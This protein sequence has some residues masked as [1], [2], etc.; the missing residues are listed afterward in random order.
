MDEREVG[1]VL[2]SQIEASEVG[3]IG[4]IAFDDGGKRE[5]FQNR[6]WTTVGRFLRNHPPEICDTNAAMV[7]YAI[8]LAAQEHYGDVESETGS[9]IWPVIERNVSER[10]PEVGQLDGSLQQK[11]GDVY[12][13]ALRHF[14][15]K[16]PED[17]SLSTGAYP[18]IGP[19]LFHAGFAG[20]TVKPVVSLV[21]RAQQSI[22]SFES[23][24]DADMRREWF[25]T[26]QSGT[27]ATLHVWPRR[28]L[29]N[30][31][32]VAEPLWQT[33]VT[34]V[35]MHD[36]DEARADWDE[37]FIRSF[38]LPGFNSRLV[39]DALQAET[40]TDVHKT[41]RGVK[42]KL[43]FGAPGDPP[44]PRLFIGSDVEA[45]L[46]MS[47]QI[48]G[49]NE[50]VEAKI[51]TNRRGTFVELDRPVE[52]VELQLFDQSAADISSP[53]RT[54]RL[55]SK[56]DPFVVFSGYGGSILDAKVVRTQGVYSGTRI[57]LCRGAAEFDG[58]N[59]KPVESFLWYFEKED[60]R[61]TAWE[62]EIPDEVHELRFSI[63]DREYDLPVSR[64]RR[65]PIRLDPASDQYRLTG[66][67]AISQDDAV[68]DV[69]S[70]HP[71]IRQD[72]G[73]P[74]MVT[75]DHEGHRFSLRRINHRCRLKPD[76]GQQLTKGSGIF[77]I[78]RW[79]FPQKE[80]ARYAVVPGLKFRCNHDPLSRKATFEITA[81]SDLGAFR[82]ADADIGL[83]Q[84]G[85]TWQFTVPCDQPTRCIEWIDFD[86]EDNHRQ[87]VLIEFAVPGVR[88]RTVHLGADTDE[89]WTDQR[90]CLE[91]HA[92]STDGT[93]L[94]IE[95]PFDWKLSLPGGQLESPGRRTFSGI[96]HRLRLTGK[97][98]V[99]FENQDGIREQ[100]VLLSDAPIVN[101]VSVKRNEGGDFE[102]TIRGHFLGAA[103]VW[104]WHTRDVASKAEPIDGVLKDDESCLWSW[105][106]S[107][108][109]GP[110]S[111]VIGTESQGPF[112][113]GVNR[114]YA[115]TESSDLQFGRFHEGFVITKPGILDLREDPLTRVAHFRKMAELTGE[116]LA[117]EDE[118]NPI[119]LVLEN[120]KFD[121]T[122][123]LA[124]IFGNEGPI[125]FAYLRSVCELQNRN[126]RPAK[127]D[128]D[129]IF[130]FHE[131][132]ELP[133]PHLIMPMFVAAQLGCHL[134]P[135]LGVDNATRL[136][137]EKAAN[138]YGNW[139]RCLGI[140]SSNFAPQEKESVLA[141]GHT[142]SIGPRL[143]WDSNSQQLI[144]NP[145]NNRLMLA[146]NARLEYRPILVSNAGA[147]T[148]RLEL[149]AN[150]LAIGQSIE[151]RV[152][153]DCQLPNNARDV[154]G[155]VADVMS[156]S[157]YSSMHAA[158]RASFDRN[159]Q[160]D[161]IWSL[162]W[163]LAGV[164][165]GNEQL[166]ELL[167]Q[168][169]T[170]AVRPFIQGQLDAFC[171]GIALAALVQSVIYN[172][173]L[174]SV[175]SFQ[176]EAHRRRPQ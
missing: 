147:T 153:R 94:E 83:S 64:D 159:H 118:V 130:D 28:I 34:I 168:I 149:I 108:S 76:H 63:N 116:V 84:S 62:I 119:S 14:R 127:Q 79:T 89:L 126:K 146:T 105:P 104:S 113:L 163:L 145:E 109:E 174:G 45:P 86:P 101:A 154:Y 125:P 5:L 55:R 160:A 140:T 88:W 157:P 77:Q 17:Y 102:L 46:L 135:V 164:L 123:D 91:K 49:T 9:A 142:Q 78:R 70:E 25:A 6:A 54:W 136:H 172:G 95:V 80:I 8:T 29:S 132:Y 134:S 139:M 37:E 100:A 40:P 99:R 38:Q 93:M 41:R 65:L 141:T 56:D 13:S 67:R 103:K 133:S 170:D 47:V 115:R 148:R 20:V 137:P 36:E 7:L 120:G 151:R 87:P 72:G 39:L 35:R 58:I 19:M 106:N 23:T 66:V 22:G 110:V 175:A 124:S 90:L 74:T 51:R 43:R 24:F 82:T 2:A 158:V 31:V 57:I 69:Y 129:A 1:E 16:T 48:D 18:N 173:G 143:R 4:L 161:Q 32:E 117:N 27:A 81:N 98:E 71:E 10:W 30:Y 114:E 165:T 75:C 131:S 92:T 52:G 42:A 53:I 128:A 166:K 61:W 156:Q 11:L 121:S 176:I 33:L 21:R 155:P 162:S 167:P 59:A 150:I 68:M 96:L 50:A 152:N 122:T 60:P 111:F 138:D 3:L 97:T 107:D 44:C 73:R 144:A 171:V 15:F 169:K 85:N 112:G 26:T 12:K